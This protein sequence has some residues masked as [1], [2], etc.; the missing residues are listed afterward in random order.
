MYYNYSQRVIQLTE[1]DKKE[2]I[3]ISNVFTTDTERKRCG[4]F[5]RFLKR[6]VRETLI[7]IKIKN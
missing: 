6:V 1:E 5:F 7:L 2:L 3:S 4:T